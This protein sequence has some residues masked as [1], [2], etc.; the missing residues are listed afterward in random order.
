[1]STARTGDHAPDHP[2]TTSPAG[3]LSFE[4]ASAR[5]LAFLDQQ[6]PMAMWAITRCDGEDQVFTEVRTRDYDVLPHPRVSW[7]G[8]L[9]RRMAGGAARVAA[10]T[11]EVPEYAECVPVEK[12]PVRAYVGAPIRLAD[13][14]VLGTVCGYHPT[15][16]EQSALERV[17]PAVELV[18]DMLAQTLLAQTLREQA[19]IREAELRRLATRDHLTGLSTRAV[20]HERLTHAL[21][22]HDAT[23]RPLSVLLI[24]VDDFKTVNDTYGHAAG[25]A[26]LV[27]VTTSWT[28]HLTPGNTLARLGGDEFALLVE[29]GYDA[30]EVTQR[31]KP[32][33]SQRLDIAGTTRTVTISVGL[34][35][36]PAEAPTPSAAG[37]LAHA[38]A[39][40]YAAKGSGG[41]RLVRYDLRLPSP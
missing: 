24:D 35:H 3:L 16:L 11:S 10:R 6:L 27:A 32:V 39:A 40:M 17:Q 14:P 36:L 1:M 30:A 12:W 22:L 26:L 31:M 20:F 18:A 38:D 41:A 9:C 2:G 25:D 34:A 33:L 8:S 23:R 13:G 15:E 4:E 37:L 29:S 5:A 28:A 7:E 21:E 19:L